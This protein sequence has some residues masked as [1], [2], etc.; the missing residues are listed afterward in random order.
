MKKLLCAGAVA[1][2]ITGLLPTLPATAGEPGPYFGQA[3]ATSI[4][5]ARIKAALHL[6][7]DQER[8]WPAVENALVAVAK[9]QRAET[10]QGGFMHRISH[11]VVSIVLDNSAIARLAAAARPLVA[12]LDQEQMQ[13]ASG[14]A[15][16]MGLGSVVAALR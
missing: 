3:A 14:L 9:R 6:R 7:A 4:N 8:Y 10:E 13:A 2:A 1:L 16:Q 12:A 11:R 15:N 5:I